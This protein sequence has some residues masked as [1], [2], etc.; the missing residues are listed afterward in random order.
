MMIDWISLILCNLLS[1][2]F[3]LDIS[4]VLNVSS[5][6]ACGREL[7]HGRINYHAIYS[8][9]PPMS[10]LSPY[11]TEVPAANQTKR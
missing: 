2:V 4:V 11:R 3:A 8:L 6:H 10:L 9:G 7:L 1:T 5:A